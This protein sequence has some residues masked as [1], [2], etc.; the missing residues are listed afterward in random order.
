LLVTVA[1]ARD[2]DSKAFFDWLGELEKSP[3]MPGLF[4][5]EVS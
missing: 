5:Q 3:G 4:R 2:I 1:E